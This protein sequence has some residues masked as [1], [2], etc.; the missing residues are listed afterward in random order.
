M[1]RLDRLI[2]D[3]SD[4]S[5]LDAEMQR[6][7]AQ[8]VD[9]RKLLTTVVSVANEV[10]HDDGVSVTLHFEGGGPQAFMVPGHDSRLG[11]VVDNLID[12]ARSFSP[13]GGTRA[14]HLPAAARTRSR[15]SSTT[16]G[17]GVPPEAMEKIFERFYTDRRIRASAR[18]PASAS[19]SPSRSSRRMAAASGRRTG[20]VRRRRTASRQVLGARFI[21]RLPA[22]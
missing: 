14:R 17:P 19:R 4:A 12:N 5:R 7:E 21:V 1:K 2:S 22:M 6:Q 16:T 18:I 20:S 9:L 10:R 8:P 11:Q 15:S 3:I 13:P